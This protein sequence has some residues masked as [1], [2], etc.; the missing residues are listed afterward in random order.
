MSRVFDQGNV[1]LHNFMKELLAVQ[2]HDHILE[3]GFGT[4]KLIA[5][6]A[7][8][9][10]TGVIEGIDVSATMVALAAKRNKRSIVEGRVILQQ[11]DFEDI[12]YPENRFDLICSANTIYFWAHPDRCV[13]K[14]WRILKPGARFLLAFEDKAQLEKRPL[15]ADVFHIYHQD[16]VQQLLN[17]NG[18]SREI[19]II[20]REIRS[21][22]FHCVVAVK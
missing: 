10:T 13:Q 16:E 14:I 11:G 1:P 12:A 17:R 22:R 6:I 3:I 4:G 2:E 18:F 8:F 7:P 20:S 21:Q 19:K 5:E 9:V 15:D